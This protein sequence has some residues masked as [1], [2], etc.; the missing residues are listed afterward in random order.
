MLDIEELLYRR[1]AAQ[2][3]LIRSAFPGDNTSDYGHAVRRALG[4]LA[5]VV[6]KETATVDSA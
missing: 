1:L 6:E 3:A 4:R 2:V 5:H